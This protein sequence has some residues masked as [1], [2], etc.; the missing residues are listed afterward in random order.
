MANKLTLTGE[1]GATYTLTDTANVEITSGT[2]FT[3]TLSATDKAAVNLLLNKNG[4][5]S[6]SAT[7]YNLAAAE[8][9]AA[10][11][12]AAVVVAD[13][14]GNGITVSNVAVPTITSATYNA[15]T[16]VLVVTGTGFLSLAGA[17]NDIVA[18]RF[19]LLGQGAFNY[20]LTDTPNVD[21]TSSTSF[22]MTMSATDK[23]A[24]ALRMNKDGTSSTDG[25]TYN[26]GGLEDWNAG[27]DAAVVIADLFGNPITVS[28]NGQP[29]APTAVIATAGN[30]KATVTFTAPA[31]T[32]LGPIT[33]YTATS[34]PGGFTGSCAGPAACTITV[35]GLTN[36]TAYTF[37]VTATN[38]FGTSA[39]S[40]PSNSVT[41]AVVTTYSAPSATGTG[42]ITAS[43][44]GGGPGC[45]FTTSQYIPVSGSPAS[46]PAGSAPVGVSFV[47][48]L[49]DF[50]T[51]GCTAGS[52]ITMTIT[53][54]SPLP[55]ST[56]YWK[57]GPTPT[58]PAPHW[59][60]L[61]ATIAGNVTTFTITDG[62]L[63]DDDLAANGT[64]VD[65]GGPGFAGAATE[66]PTLSEW[67]MILLALMLGWVGMRRIRAA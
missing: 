11:A 18:N 40:L 49:F 31:S 44:T 19:R 6:T 24:L 66:V 37:T 7:T 16:G 65:Q 3:L 25:T 12:D 41:P 42:I 63:G 21:I 43:F 57:Y 56:Q 58:D 55:A 38:A 22:T 51:G 39:P 47:H 36:G 15:S 67:A 50:T 10:G 34:S 8:D 27:A 2:A 4:T 32:G 62:G 59:Y 1:G 5:S 17:A 64:I 48:G 61:P 45:S 14:T 60:V 9:W 20:T 23:A 13:L 26:L 30:L 46:P 28:G 52:T 35:A 33:S 53:W 29:G 54:P